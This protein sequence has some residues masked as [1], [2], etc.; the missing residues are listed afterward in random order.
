MIKGNE[1]KKLCPELCLAKIPEKRGKADLSNYR[2]ASADVMAVLRRF[3]KQIEKA[4]ID[5][6]FIDIT[7]TVEKRISDF[8]FNRVQ[9][10][11]LKQTHLASA[12]LQSSSE[13]DE[14]PSASKEGLI[15][16]NTVKKDDSRLLMLERWLDG[17]GNIGEVSLAV[18]AMVALEIRDA[19]YTETGFTCSA[20]IGHNKVRHAYMCI[21]YTIQL[22]SN[23]VL[24]VILSFIC[25]KMLAKLAAGMN[26]P[27]QQTLLPASQVLNVF[28][29]TPFKKLYVYSTVHVHLCIV[30]ILVYVRRNLGGKF[31]ENVRKT[32][33]IEYVGELSKY[34]LKRL[35]T[36]FGTKNG[37]VHCVY[38]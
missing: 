30:Y 27:N 9:V 37:L 29:S 4:S 15:K 17:E 21:Q 14:L 11:D 38:N 12:K 24:V 6:A 19:V 5:E 8:S 7:A 32:L 1:G 34:T 22:V 10:N 33:N 25:L 20:G 3:S 13:E 18:G 28:N 31:G 23:R 2:K 35:Q 26:K 36:A 16:H